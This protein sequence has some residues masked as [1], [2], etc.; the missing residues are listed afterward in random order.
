[1]VSR[2]RA[3]ALSLL[4]AACWVTCGAEPLGTEERLG[5]GV[6]GGSVNLLATNKQPRGKGGRKGEDGETKTERNS[7]Q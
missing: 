7:N 6:G 5:L 4:A 2:A 1:M 3:G